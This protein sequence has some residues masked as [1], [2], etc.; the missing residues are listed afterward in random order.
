MDIY[1]EKRGYAQKRREE[2]RSLTKTFHRAFSTTAFFSPFFDFFLIHLTMVHV[3]SP[4]SENVFS[5]FVH[6]SY[7]FFH[8]RVCYS[9]VGLDGYRT[10]EFRENAKNREKFCDTKRIGFYCTRMKLSYVQN[11]DIQ[12]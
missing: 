7:S 3:F 1:R 12:Y 5:F 8:C 10:H 9:C 6:S 2:A 4:K 11:V